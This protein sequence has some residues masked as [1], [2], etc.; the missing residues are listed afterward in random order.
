ME[1]KWAP[2]GANEA[3]MDSRRTCGAQVKLKGA[4]MEPKCAQMDPNGAQWQWSQIAV[5]PNGSSHK[6]NVRSLSRAKVD[7]EGVVGG[8]DWTSSNLIS[9][10]HLLCSTGFTLAP[11]A[12]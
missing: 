6:A 10:F 4:Q 8:D 1:L 5:E 7:P 3:H 12:Y 11:N 9:T 2:V